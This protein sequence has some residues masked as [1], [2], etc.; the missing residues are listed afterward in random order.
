MALASWMNHEEE[1]AAEMRRISTREQTEK[2]M[3][4]A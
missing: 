2:L 4:R 3:I 1:R